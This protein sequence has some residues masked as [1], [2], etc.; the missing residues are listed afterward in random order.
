MGCH[1]H[2]EL[3]HVSGPCSSFCG[4]GNAHRLLAGWT[5]HEDNHNWH[6]ELSLHDW[7]GVAFKATAG[8]WK[9][10][11]TFLKAHVGCPTRREPTSICDMIGMSRL[12]GRKR[13]AGNTSLESGLNSKHCRF[14]SLCEIDALST[15]YQERHDPAC[16]VFDAGMQLLSCSSKATRPNLG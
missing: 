5:C 7:R 3:R 11:L 6:S 10:R 12:S 8:C 16:N 15:D 1:H 13:N 4:G 2:F 9:S 14:S